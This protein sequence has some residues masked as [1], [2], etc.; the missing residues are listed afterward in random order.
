MSK[1]VIPP[2]KFP[3]VLAAARRGDFVALGDLLEASRSYLLFVANERL[4]RVLSAKVGDSDLVQETFLSVQKCFGQFRGST[5]AELLVWLR[6]GLVYRIAN[7]LRAFKQTAK[8]N[9]AREISLS[10]AG[11]ESRQAWQLAEKTATPDVSLAEQ[12]QTLAMRFGMQLLSEDQRALI[13]LRFLEKL[14]WEAI[15]DQLGISS[16]A[17]RKQCTR[18]M[19]RLG[20]IAKNI[21]MYEMGEVR[22]V[23]G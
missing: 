5:E 10:S 6:Q 23:P 1:T 16:E 12:E 22:G 15:A 3:E 20:T 19:I 13:G 11:Q 7:Q 2:E 17:A 21:Q 4:P 9:V 8:R 18:A 14:P